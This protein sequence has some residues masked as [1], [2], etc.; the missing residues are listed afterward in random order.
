M[1]SCVLQE[2]AES[3]SSSSEEE[4]PPPAPAPAPVQTKAPTPEPEPEPVPVPSTSHVVHTVNRFEPAVRGRQEIPEG[5]FDP[6]SFLKYVY[7]L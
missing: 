7:L 2:V 4:L 6:Q 1:Y 3:S 5:R